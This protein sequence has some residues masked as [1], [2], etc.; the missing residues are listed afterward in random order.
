M[1]FSS[2]PEHFWPLLWGG[3]CIALAAVLVAENRLGQPSAGEGRRAPARV[4]EAKLL[5]AF[6]LPPEQQAGNEMLARPLFVPGRRPAPVAA[7]AGGAMKKGQFVLQ[8]TTITGALS[9]AMLKEVATGVV[10]RV[11]KGRDLQGMTL[12][13]VAP[14][15]VVLR[16]GDDS[17]T[18]ML[19]VAK[20]VGN[21][22]AAIQQGPFA[23]PGAPAAAG[24]PSATTGTARVGSPA[25]G[26]V[27]PPAAPSRLMPAVGA[28]A[29]PYGA[30][31]APAATA[32]NPAP[33]T[34]EEILA[35]RRAA[36]RSQ[37]QN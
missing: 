3:A 36:R 19:V 10:H 29:G 13:E 9:I 16:A 28:M 27:V 34:A 22:T 8:G 21:A 6:R 1:V 2:K 12:A 37:P 25:P 24:G 23:S 5:P 4:V 15:H 11:E 17:E 31:A 20:G 26:V 18:L 33:M 7:S 14:E 32:T 30:A 35:R